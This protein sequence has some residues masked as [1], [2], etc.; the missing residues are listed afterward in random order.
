MNE[1]FALA[2]ALVSG[3]NQATQAKPKKTAAANPMA[4]L[5]AQQQA[6]EAANC[7]FLMDMMA[8]QQAQQAAM[9]QQ[10]MAPSAFGWW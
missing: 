9:L 10:M 5:V 1:L 3:I 6:A 4:E 8:Q 7:Q 2:M